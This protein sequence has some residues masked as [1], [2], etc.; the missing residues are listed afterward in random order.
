VRNPISLLTTE[1][2]SEICY[3]AIIVGAGA[4]GLMA[5]ICARHKNLNVLLLDSKSKIG[6]KILMSGG[7]RCNITN[8][9]IED[10]DFQ[11]ESLRTVGRVLKQFT[12]EQARNFFEGLGLSLVLEDGGKYFPSTHSGRT[13]LE[14]FLNEATKVNLVIKSGFSVEEVIKDKDCFFVDGHNFSYKAKSVLLTTGG[15]SF[16][17]TGSNGK[18]YELAASFGH[19]Q[20]KTS[21]S[22][23]PLTTSDNDWKSLSGL[24]L[25]VGLSLVES[26]K[27]KASYRGSFLFT[28]FGYSGPV[29][30]NISRH[31]IRREGD[32]KLKA[33]FLPE[34]S[35]DVFREKLQKEI[36]IQPKK[37]IKNLLNEILPNRFV[38]VILH[39]LRLSKTL[40]LNQLTR[41]DRENIITFLKHC[42][43]S[44]SGDK[45]YAKAE[46]TAGGIPFKEVNPSSLES[47][48]QRGLFFAGEILDVDGRIGGFNF[49]WAWSSAYVAV[50]GIESYLKTTAQNN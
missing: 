33:D 26:G 29:V 12:S 23:T 46:V 30:L 10:R 39:K 5:G 3:D 48:K 15:L 24:S 17:A 2:H 4:A 14:A 16:P 28:H 36:E 25:D 1:S 13:V 7:T 20:I 50:Q 32:A 18:G 43:L 37:T 27:K 47:L 19:S 34:W 22:L 38:E 21:P 41:G 49:Q 11:S 44:V 35:D 8:Q 31:W 6:A 45:G 40:I 42:P 9:K